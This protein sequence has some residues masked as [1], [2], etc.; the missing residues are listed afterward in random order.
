M[1]VKPIDIQVLP[2]KFTAPLPIAE[3]KNRLQESLGKAMGDIITPIEGEVE[4]LDATTYKFSVYQRVRKFGNRSIVGY[5]YAQTDSSTLVDAVFAIENEKKSA[6]G[7]MTVI[8]VI[9]IVAVMFI[10][11]QQI[12][13]ALISPIILG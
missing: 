5:L 9:G 6:A 8:V 7:F 10:S 3:C 12:I 4:M 1:E 11:V 2:I 13:V